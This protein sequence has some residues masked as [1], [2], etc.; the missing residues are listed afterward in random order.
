MTCSL[1]QS[2]HT[3]IQSLDPRGVGNY[4][5]FTLRFTTLMTSSKITKAV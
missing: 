5:A 1:Q 4:M 3:V 2:Q